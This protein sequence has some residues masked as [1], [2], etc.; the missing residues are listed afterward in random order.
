MDI[1]TSCR[2]LDDWFVGKLQDLSYKPETIAYV[3][4]VLKEQGHPKDSFDG[5]SIF[6]AFQDARLHG[7]FAKYQ[8]LGD[9]IL[10][11]DVVLPDSIKNEREA[12][13]AVG[14][15]SYY[16]CY[17]LLHYRWHLYEELADQLPNLVKR[18]RRHLV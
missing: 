18:V 17:K 11:V 6:L 2:N 4:G 12:V 15:L 7:S 16:A 13:E 8:R 14:R 10:W 9:W 5:H 3:V 1:I